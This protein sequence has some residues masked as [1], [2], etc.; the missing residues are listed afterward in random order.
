M[1]RPTSREE[2][3]QR[4]GRIA[5]R[6][7]NGK[8]SLGARRFVKNSDGI[9]RPIQRKPASHE[10]PKRLGRD[11]GRVDQEQRDHHADDRTDRRLPA[12]RRGRTAQSVQD[13][14]SGG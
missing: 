1:P 5:E 7:K 10:E 13:L 3:Q 2:N 4:H 12:S 6:S 9:P 8:R 11:E 14:D